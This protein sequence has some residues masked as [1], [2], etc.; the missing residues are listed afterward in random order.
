MKLT[1]K[2][3]AAAAIMVAPGIA[4]AGPLSAV[5]DGFTIL[6][7]AIKVSA[8]GATDSGGFGGLENL[9]DG[10]LSTGFPNL[11]NGNVLTFSF[12][13]GITNEA[14]ADFL[15][16]DGRYDAGFISVTV[17]GGSLAFDADDFYDTGVDDAL[18][19]AISSYTYDVFALLVDLSDFGIADGANVSGF[20]MQTLSGSAFDPIDVAAIREGVVTAPVP[21]PAGLPLLLGGLGAL[22]LARRKRKTA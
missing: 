4:A 17:G 21:L 3:L 15:I 19:D 16:I 18:E 9:V 22:G 14:G 6:D 10:D 13:G 8:S 5:E 20:S 12:D 2:T 11:D 7:G 1:R